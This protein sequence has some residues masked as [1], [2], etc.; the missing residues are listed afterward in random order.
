MGRA[1][2]L[3]ATVWRNSCDLDAGRRPVLSRDV[4]GHGCGCE[5]RAADLR[6]GDHL[7]VARSLP[8]RFRGAY[9]LDRC[10]L[11]TRQSRSRRGGER[12]GGNGADC[13]GC[14]SGKGSAVRRRGQPRPR[15]PEPALLVVSLCGS[16]WDR[17]RPGRGHDRRRRH[18][19]RD[20]DRDRYLPSHMAGECPLP[21][22]RN[23][24][25]HSGGDRRWHAPV[26]VLPADHLERAPG[27]ATG[28]LLATRRGIWCGRDG[29]LPSS[30]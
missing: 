1:L 2:R 19:C 22:D 10:R 17:H 24:A 8:T 5:R 16:R 18:S 26:D 29:W 12:Q 15:W 28:P 20:G 25:P 7:A 14:R 27:C 9:G 11:Q 13:G 30:W 23:G 6:P 21:G 4:P 3:P